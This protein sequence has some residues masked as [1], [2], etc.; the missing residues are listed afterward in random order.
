[1]TSG[2]NV[3]HVKFVFIDCKSLELLETMTLV[4]LREMADFIEIVPWGFKHVL[5]MLHGNCQKIAN[6]SSLDLISQY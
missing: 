4:V 3:D 2:L 6:K 5:P 1:M